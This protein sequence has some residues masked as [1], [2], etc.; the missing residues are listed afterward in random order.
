MKLLTYI[1]DRM[2]AR[3]NYMLWNYLRSLP[4]DTLIDYGFSPELIAQGVSA[5]PWREDTT[6]NDIEIIKQHI[7]EER[8][9]INALNSL[10]DAELRDIGVA[11]GSIAEA[12][13]KGRPGIEHEENAKA[14]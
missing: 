4:K 9:S 8:L 6:I 10:T 1:I 3:S 14:A 7:E 13:R 12:V 5:W 2:Q 11:R